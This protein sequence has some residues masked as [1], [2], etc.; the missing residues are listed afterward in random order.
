MCG[1]AL[2]A[3]HS[4]ISYS[5]ALRTGF[6]AKGL[7]SGDHHTAVNALR[8]F[9]RPNQVDGLRHLKQLLAKKSA[10]AYGSRRLAY[11]DYEDVLSRT[12]RFI[13]WANRIG[14]EMNVGGWSDA[15]E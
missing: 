14:S 6:G 8:Q 12:E 10:I 2:L 13:R 4:A 11:E 9:L 15:G 7:T 5:D 1:A 3:I